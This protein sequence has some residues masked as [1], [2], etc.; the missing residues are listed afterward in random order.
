[1]AIENIEIRVSLQRALLGEIYPHIRAIGYSYDSRN[2]N[3][4]LRYYVDREPTEDDYDSLSSVM[5]EFIGDYKFSEFNE[6]IRTGPDGKNQCPPQK[7][8][9]DRQGVKSPKWIMN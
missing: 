2:K 5:G 7:E 1:M 9:S 4:L 3:F 8:I 6:I